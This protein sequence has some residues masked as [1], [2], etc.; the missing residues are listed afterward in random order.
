M[1]AARWRL[2]LGHY[3]EARL[4]AAGELGELN[5]QRDQALDYLYRREYGQQRGIRKLAPGSLDPSQVTAV[6]WLAK[7]RELFP[8]E[9]V[10]IIEAH[11]LQRY[12]LTELLN[13]PVVLEQ[14]EPN[15]A[16][17]R[18]LLSVRSKL[19]A[20][21]LSAARR[22]IRQVVAEIRRKLEAEVRSTLAGRRNRMRASPMAVAQNF[23]ARG[24]VRRNLKHYNR[25]RQQLIIESA[26]FFDRNARRLPWDVILC[27]DQS[28]S[29]VD[30]VIHSAVM[31]GILC[32]LPALRVRLVLFDTDT[33]D[34]SAHVDDPVE[35]L[36]RVQLGGGTNIARALNYCASRIENPQRTVLILISD[37]FEGGPPTALL[38]ITKHLLAERV[39]LIG[40]AS[41]A[42]VEVHYDRQ[43]AGQLAELGMKIAALTPREL[44]RWLVGVIS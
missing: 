10:E 33:V 35:V 13:D 26:R 39:R 44:A 15:L 12:G 31:A 23:D 29:M 3:A 28:G 27:V 21:V 1:T 42:G 20:D 25:E 9:S 5:A 30:S 36:M 8:K 22:I 4:G 34:L 7:V 41:L 37:F 24:T 43:M 32:A 11:A 38:R 40:L 19:H 6:D 16:L 18:T 2:L 17:L 14:L